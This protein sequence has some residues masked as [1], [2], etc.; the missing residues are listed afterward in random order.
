MVDGGYLAKLDWSRIPNQQYIN[1]TFKGLWWDPNDEYQL[2]KDWDDRSPLPEAAR[3][4]PLTSWK[5]PFD[6]ATGPYSGKV[7]LVDSMAT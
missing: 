1:P 7:V 5:E 4:E 3:H 2:P 6:L